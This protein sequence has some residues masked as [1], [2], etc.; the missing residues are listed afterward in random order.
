M[1]HFQ[2]TTPDGQTHERNSSSQVYTHAVIHNYGERWGVLA[3]SSS[4]A[5][6]EKAA[7]GHRN[8]FPP[9][10]MQVVEVEVAA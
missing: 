4:K 3:W 2:V 10:T 1:N 8:V 7:W 5:L 6:A 9:E